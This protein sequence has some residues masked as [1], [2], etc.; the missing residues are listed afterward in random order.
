MGPRACRS[1]SADPRRS[2]RS[3]PRPRAAGLPGGRRRRRRA[4]A[5][6]RPARAR[7]TT[8]SGLRGENRSRAADSRSARAPDDQDVVRILRID[9]AVAVLDAHRE[10]QRRI[11]SPCS[12]SRGGRRAVRG[13]VRARPSGEATVRAPSW[14]STGSRP[15]VSA[16]SKAAAT[17]FTGPAGTPAARSRPTHS[18]TGASGEPALDQLAQRGAVG[19][20]RRGW[21]QSGRRRRARA[22]RAPRRARRTDGRFRRRSS[23]ARRRRRRSRTARCW[24]GRSRAGRGPLPAF[25]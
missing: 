8:A 16:S 15:S 19:D 22:S 12:S 4:S 24:D 5:R 1:R 13:G 9:V 2:S 23:A 7:G 17:S 11:S 18:A 25:R 3:A 14:S 6:G 10:S 21:W 20:P